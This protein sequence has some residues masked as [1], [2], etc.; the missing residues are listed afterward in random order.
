MKSHI[1]EAL[2][3][4]LGTNEVDRIIEC[5][6]FTKKERKNAK[7]DKEM[8]KELQDAF[9]TEYPI[10]QPLLSIK[11]VEVLRTVLLLASVSE[12]VAEENKDQ[13]GDN[14]GK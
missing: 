14:D 10:L 7:L 11:S 1:K 13:E 6:L 9:G 5:E 8:Y 2:D 4:V 12:E 3:H